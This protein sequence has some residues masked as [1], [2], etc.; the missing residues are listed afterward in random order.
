MLPLLFQEIIFYH[1]CF[2]FKQIL[3]ISKK[4]KTLWEDFL[5]VSEMLLPWNQEKRLDAFENNGNKL[6]IGENSLKCFGS[7]GGFLFFPTATVQG[8]DCRRKMTP[9]NEM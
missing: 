6:I 1:Y 7:D 2:P 4:K 5:R 3:P 8:A 9:G